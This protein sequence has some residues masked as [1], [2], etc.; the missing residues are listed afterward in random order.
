M[1]D[2]C[3]QPSGL[4]DKLESSADDQLRGVPEDMAG[5]MA[6]TCPLGR[7]KVLTPSG[8]SLS[9]IIDAATSE[10]EKL[11]G[12]GITDRREVEK[13]RGDGRTGRADTGWLGGDSGR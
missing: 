7:W 8:F 12:R 1:M 6:L 9:A 3:G 5:L 10:V 2:G 11:D 13:K 4:R